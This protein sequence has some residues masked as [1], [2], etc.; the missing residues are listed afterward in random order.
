MISTTFI[1]EHIVGVSIVFTIIVFT[2]IDTFILLH[3][4]QAL[5]RP[6]S[7]PARNSASSHPQQERDI[8]R[9][10]SRKR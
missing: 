5:V 7:D 10:C 2:I 8:G 4:I 1:D 3:H 6:V 9:K